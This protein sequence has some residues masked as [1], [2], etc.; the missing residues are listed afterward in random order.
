M[1]ITNMTLSLLLTAGLLAP[2]AQAGQ[3]DDACKAVLN[4]ANSGENALKQ[5]LASGADVNSRDDD[6]ETP[7][8]RAADD[9]HTAIV[10]TLLKSGADVNAIDEDG[11]TALMMAAEE[12]HAQI[13]KLLLDAGANANAKDEDGE[14]ALQ[15]ALDDNHA[16]VADML[17]K[18]GAK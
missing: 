2:L 12:G 5:H 8:M 3:K 15:K 1:K 7:L 16:E 6:G 10:E 9:G 11:E 14:T 17:R 13:V 18:A 4:A